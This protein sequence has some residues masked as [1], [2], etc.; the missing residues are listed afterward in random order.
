MENSTIELWSLFSFLN[1]GL[2]G[3][4]NYFKGSFAKS[5]EQ[6]RD[7]ETA[8]LLKR[9]VFPFILRRTKDEVEKDLP[10]KVENVVYCEMSH[11]QNKL[12][13]QW[14]DYYRAALMKQIAEV[15]IDKSRMNVLQGLTKLRQIA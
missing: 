3:N 12:Y 2:L 14:R 11:P 9:M 7:Q 8:E 15:G 6:N 4:L 1:P 10:P 5:I 13:K